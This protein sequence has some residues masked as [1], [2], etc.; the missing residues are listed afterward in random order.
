[1]GN[2]VIADRYYHDNIIGQIMNE[3]KGKKK[4]FLKRIYQKLFQVNTIILKPDL[5]IF[6]DVSPEVAYNRKQD[7]SYETMLK[8]NQAYKNYMY[9]REEVTIIDADKPPEEIYSAVVNQIIKLDQ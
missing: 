7:Y 3:D 8:V 4:S 2:I 5:T 1:M 9:N 6:L